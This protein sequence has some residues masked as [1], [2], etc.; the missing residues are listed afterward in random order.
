M[1]GRSMRG[2]VSHGMFPPVG[3]SP[4]PLCPRLGGSF[5][6]LV[7][8][9]L[10]VSIPSDG[11]P[12]HAQDPT[13][14]PDNLAFGGLGSDDVWPPEGEFSV[15]SGSWLSRKLRHPDCGVQVLPIYYADLHTNTRG[16]I[17]TKDATRYQGLL[18]LGVTIDLDQARCPIP[19][20]LHLLG[21]TTHGEGLTEN[22]VGDSLVVSDIDSFRNTTQIGEYWWELQFLDEAVTLRLGKQDVNTEFVYIE[23]A[24]HFV[25]S[26]FELTPNS[27]LPT[28]P[29]QSMGAVALIQL[30]P[31]LQLKLGAWDALADRGSW[32]FSGNSTVFLVSELEYKYTM[33]DG[34]LPGTVGVA[35]GY[36]SPGVLR[37]EPIDAVHGYALQWEQVVFRESGSDPASVQGLAM[38][39]AYYPRF[40]GPDRLPEAIGDSASGGLVYA[41][42][43]PR[44]DLDSFGVGVSWGQLF[45]GGSNQETAFEIFYRAQ[46]TPRISL[47]PD[48]QYIATPSGI[49]PDS[50]VAG[51]RFQMEL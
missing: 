10:C 27:T 34:S 40:F 51:L 19:G 15:R 31:S 35:A 32:G 24:V 37:E 3:R 42:I 44:R 16:G 49:H 12:L 50:L 47:Q 28:Y 8:A 13:I 7:L 25:Q 4:G 48:L 38:F 41:G 22:F 5:L 33:G 17:S 29:Y 45:Q 36:Q 18:D 26:S 6:T 21:Q 1:T 2:A 30:N 46:L 23:T 20:R 39:A 11:R 43:L 9:A 14:R